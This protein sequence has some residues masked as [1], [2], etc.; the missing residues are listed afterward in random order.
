MF[1]IYSLMSRKSRAFKSF[2][3]SLSYRGTECRNCG[4]PLEL[5]DRYCPYCS[6][7]N[8]NKS[9]SVRNYF[10][11]FLSS[12]LVYDSKLRYTLRDLFSPARMTI[13]YVKG[14]HQKYANP[15]RFFL[16]VSIIYTLISLFISQTDAEN[17]E[18]SV[19]VRFVSK[20]SSDVF[21]ERPPKFLRSKEDK[22]TAKA[23][24]LTI[25]YYF[26]EEDLKAM[27]YTME[28][29]ERA[30][31]Y[32]EY[33]YQYP[34]ESVAEALKKLG[35]QNNFS[36]RWLYLRMITIRKIIKDP[37]GFR[38]FLAPKFP[39]FI[40]FFTPVFGFFFWLIYSKRRFLYMEH[41]IFLFHIFSFYFLS[42][43]ILLI[44]ELILKK[45]FFEFLFLFTVLP[46]YLYKA[47]RRFYQDKPWMTLLKFLILGF[48]FNVC[49]IIGILIFVAGSVVMY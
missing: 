44:P 19:E 10:A 23:D 46:V 13:N 32:A 49:F 29:K 37:E 27:S 15:F 38:D 18:K 47:L 12:I 31:L 45:S 21:K 25:P 36:N 40:F 4:H 5:S 22:A 26:S 43:L 28:K 39:F 30:A 11:E 1:Y 42:K 2:R 8:S 34:E 3:K 48:I 33:H 6:Q 7:A 14:Q 35:H 16:S 24:H 9:L 20:D 41:L 17:G